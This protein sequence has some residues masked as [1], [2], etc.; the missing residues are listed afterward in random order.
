MTKHF[1]LKP[2]ESEIASL[3][4]DGK[5]K[6]KAGT[7][8]QTAGGLPLVLMVP[9]SSLASG[10]TRQQILPTMTNRW[11]KIPAL[12]ISEYALSFTEISKQSKKEGS[13][14]FRKASALN[15]PP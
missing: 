10:A 1:R 12:P 13:T 15:L 14:Y 11:G 5:G 8:N 4:P 9:T 2:F 3:A 6:S 7:E